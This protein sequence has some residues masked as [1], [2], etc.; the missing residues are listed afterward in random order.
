MSY[1]KCYVLLEIMKTIGVRV[2]TLN[3]GISLEPCAAEEAEQ[4]NPGF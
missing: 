1:Q 4:K 3:E 2:K